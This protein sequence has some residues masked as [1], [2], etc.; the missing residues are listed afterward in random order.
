MQK[1]KKKYINLQLNNNY[2]EDVYLGLGSNMGDRKQHLSDAIESIKNSI[3]VILKC[4]S[5]IETE[6]WGFKSTPFL[7]QVILISTGLNPDQ[8]LK[9]LQLIETKMGRI[10]KTNHNVQHLVYA[11]RPIDID[12]LIYGLQKI[13][14]EHLTIPHP[15]MFERD[16][17]LIPLKEII[18]GTKLQ[19]IQKLYE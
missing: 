6:S 8:L 17:V 10:A 12:I 18:D 16:F 13:Q 19:Q 2:M 5:I 4:S 7:N 11:D 14:N 15:R 1:Y 3:G 9:Q